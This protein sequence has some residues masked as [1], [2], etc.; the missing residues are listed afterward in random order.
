MC[1]I[2]A[3]CGLNK[4]GPHSPIVVALLGGRWSGYGIVGENVS[5]GVGLEVSEA[6]S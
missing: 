2:Y 3:Y 1:Y 4:N 6:K 5:L